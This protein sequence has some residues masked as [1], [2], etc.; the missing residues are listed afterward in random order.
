M[1]AV[2][3]QPAGPVAMT[4]GKGEAVVEVWVWGLSPA[5]FDGAST[6]VWISSTLAGSR[7]SQAA[8]LAPI[9]FS[10][11]RNLLLSPA[12]KRESLS[13]TSWRG[14]W[15]PRT[16]GWEQSPPLM[17][18]KSS[19]QEKPNKREPLNTSKLNPAP[20]CGLLFT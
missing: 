11:S 3:R 4:P 20:S 15:Q 7:G 8:L 14:C 16:A 19:S 6:R 9:I 17:G 10:P 13:P 5:W 18:G 1:P 12:R 2:P